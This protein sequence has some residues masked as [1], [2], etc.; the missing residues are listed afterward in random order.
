MNIS[1]ILNKL[2]CNTAFAKP[3]EIVFSEYQFHNYPQ[4]I[5]FITQIALK[6]ENFYF[7]EES[8]SSTNKL[9]NSFECMNIKQAEKLSKK[10]DKSIAAYIKKYGTAND[11]NKYNYRERGLIRLKGKENYALY[12]KKLGIDLIQS[13]YNAKR[14]YIAARIA[15][16]YWFHNKCNEKINNLEE[17]T[18]TVQGNIYSI[19][20]II[21]M[22][23]II[24]SPNQKGDI[25]A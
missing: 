8:F 17:L 22:I 25:N 16:E 21:E 7:T 4:L 23:N 6:S 2:Q 14:D 19:D 15:L 24:K 13:P 10:G 1:N 12:G 9:I 11:N 5:S 20:K 18:R 3:L